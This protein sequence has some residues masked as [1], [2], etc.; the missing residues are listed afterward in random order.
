MRVP[1]RNGFGLFAVLLLFPALVLAFVCLVGAGAGKVRPKPP[2]IAA[3]PPAPKSPKLVGGGPA[4]R[5]PAP[6]D[7]RPKQPVG[8]QIKLPAPAPG[9]RAEGKEKEKEKE[10]EE[11]VRAKEGDG[12]WFNFE[13]AEIKTVLKHLSE[14]AGL[15]ILVK[16]GDLQ[17]R[18]TLQSRKRLSVDEAIGVLN[19][20][21]KEMGYAGVRAGNTLKIVKMEE[22]VRSNVPVRVG[23]DPESIPETDEIVTQIIPLR[24]VQARQLRQDLEPLFSSN[25]VVSANEDSNSL[26]IT[27]TSANVHRIAKVIRA[28]DSA[29]TSAAKVEVF[30]LKYAD[31]TD[32]AR[33]ITQIFQSQSQRDSRGGPRP[34]FSFFFRRG[35]PPGRGGSDRG[36]SA[37]PV[38]TVPVI[39][40]ADDRTNTVVVSGP[41]ETLEVI[42]GVLEKLDSNPASKQDVFIYR[43]K[44]GDALQIEGVLNTI[45][46][47]G[48]FTSRGYSR[49]STRS[50]P[51]SSRLGSR[52]SFG[53]S[54]F[55]GGGFP[56]SR[57]SSPFGGGSFGRRSPFLSAFRAGGGRLSSR[58]IESAAELYGQVYAVADEDTNSLLV[59][60]PSAAKDTVRSIIEELDRPVPQVLIKL[61]I[62]E[63]THTDSV[64]LGADFSILDVPGDSTLS[65]DFSVGAQSGGI[66][67]RLVRHDI[68][69]VLRALAEKSKLEVLSRPYI[70]ASDNQEATI[71]VGQEVPFIR[72]T[73]ITQNDATINTI[74]YEDVGIIVTVTPHINP[75]GLVTIDISPEISAISGETVPISE[76]VD[77]PVIAKRSAST[78]IAIRDG[79]TIV[80]GGLMEDR[81]TESVS[82][83]PILGD[84]PLLGSLLSRKENTTAKTEL[85]IFLTPHVASTPDVLKGMTKQEKK[86]IELLD[87]AVEGGA[88]KKHLEGLRRGGNKKQEETQRSAA[89]VPSG[90]LPEGTEEKQRP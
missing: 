24:R 67:Y 85:L 81:M 60:C 4:V 82:K 62:A 30:P 76:T 86:G 88:F 77:A 46:G 80:I 23:G 52:S 19:S 50:V 44:N 83:V 26:I 2:Q 31:A 16:D 57:S 66:I 53:R 72:N 22:A 90:G 15:V 89:A 6:E 71:T 38:A 64:D 25:A 28:L 65:T 7:L 10:P 5:Q 45:F 74:E 8:P 61:L 49:G 48:S 3:P 32:A 36:R 41:P 59:M 11:P 29:E 34:P 27:D 84:I 40:S 63:V 55:R 14:V 21:L 70:L 13:N 9:V 35:G 1:S 20:V 18:V 43:V 58:S 17:G 87:K 56:F 69:A 33:L 47:T 12:I 37:G 79:Q 78:R 68:E 39:A 75:E 51:T 54:S 42:R 73:R